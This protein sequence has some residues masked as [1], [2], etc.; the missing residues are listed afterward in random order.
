MRDRRASLPGA[1]RRLARRCATLAA[2]P[3][4]VRR[5]NAAARSR[6]VERDVMGKG[7]LAGRLARLL[8]DDVRLAARLRR[9]RAP[10]RRAQSSFVTAPP[11]A[12]RRSGDVP[13]MS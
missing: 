11:P 13:T 8:R 9:W 7:P 10:L 3:P 1:W 12:G 6:E 4:L 2:R 5:P